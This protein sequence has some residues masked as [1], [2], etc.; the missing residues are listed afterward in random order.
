M[1][2]LT[3]GDSWRKR[4]CKCCGGKLV[5]DVEQYSG[6]CCDCNYKKLFGYS[7]EEFLER[8]DK[9]EN[10]EKVEKVPKSGQLTLG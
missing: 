9:E 1:V 7:F 4:K 10:V 5:S 6:E 2:D 8:R 3:S